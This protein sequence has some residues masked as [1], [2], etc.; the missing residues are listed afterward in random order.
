MDW[1]EKRENSG[2]EYTTCFFSDQ[3]LFLPFLLNNYL[4]P[5]SKQHLYCSWW[6]WQDITCLLLSAQKLFFIVG[7]FFPNPEH[8]GYQKNSKASQQLSFFRFSVFSSFL[9]CAFSILKYL[10]LS[11][12]TVGFRMCF[13]Y[14]WPVPNQKTK[15]LLFLV[16][17]TVA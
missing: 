7:F 17:S 16:L 11:W 8:I 3:R 1:G 5:S 10:L 15:L 13:S 9:M 2:S 12:L 14:S 4:F 6:K